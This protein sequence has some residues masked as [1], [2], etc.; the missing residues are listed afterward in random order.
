MELSMERERA[1]KTTRSRTSETVRRKSLCNLQKSEQGR[2][3]KHWEELLRVSNKSR[4]RREAGGHAQ[5]AAALTWREPKGN[6]SGL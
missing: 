2:T 1:E 3:A 4:E 6:Y 5:A